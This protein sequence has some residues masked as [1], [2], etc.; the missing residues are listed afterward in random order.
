MANIKDIASRATTRA[1]VAASAT[2]ESR[3]D[4]A[5]MQTEMRAQFS[6]L[7]T[8]IAALRTDVNR[9][10]GAVA[11]VLANSEASNSKLELIS[12]RL[13]SMAFSRDQS[14]VVDAADGTRPEEPLKSAVNRAVRHS[15]MA[16]V[17]AG[18]QPSSSAAGAVDRYPTQ[19]VAVQYFA[20]DGSTSSSYLQDAG[21]GDARPQSEPL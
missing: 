15:R 20:L 19:S 2:S 12:Q 16:T 6:A 4:R 8:D 21:C 9:L 14:D 3:V 13:F 1:S 11:S 18:A 5:T 17:T 10:N 7:A